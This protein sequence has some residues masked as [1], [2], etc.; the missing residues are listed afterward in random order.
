MDHQ[1]SSANPNWCPECHQHRV[2]CS[3]DPKI[4]I[5]LVDY[6]MVVIGGMIPHWCDEQVR[7]V[8]YDEYL[9]ISRV[10]N[11][12]LTT[13]SIWWNE[14][15]EIT[16]HRVPFGEREVSITKVEIYAENVGDM[17]KACPLPEIFPHEE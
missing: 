11:W 7:C 5:Y 14:K 13:E 8:A 15:G 10:T 16:E 12:A 6:H 3:C 2:I 1:V 17:L 4:H 9:A